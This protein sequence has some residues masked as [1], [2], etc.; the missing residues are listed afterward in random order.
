MGGFR[1]QYTME[2]RDIEP[3]EGRARPRRQL[4]RMTRWTLLP[5]S[6]D[7]GE[8]AEEA[9]AANSAFRQALA[10]FRPGRAT[11]TIWVYRRQLRRLPPDPQRTLSLGPSGGRP[12]AAPGRAHRRLAGR[13]QVGGTMRAEGG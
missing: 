5:E 8:T 12:A 9:L 13:N 10:K 6:D 2:R 4:A 1:L 11:I 3:D 7:M